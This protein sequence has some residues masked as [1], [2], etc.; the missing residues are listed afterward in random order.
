[1][2]TSGFHNPLAHTHFNMFVD[3][4][5]PNESPELQ[6]AFGQECSQFAYRLYAIQCKYYWKYLCTGDL[7]NDGILIEM[8]GTWNTAHM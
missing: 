2:W 6:S 3:E 5:T 7:D 1:M 4:W 8:A